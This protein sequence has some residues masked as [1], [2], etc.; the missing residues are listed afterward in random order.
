M[1]FS[2]RRLSTRHEGLWRHTIPEVL[3]SR[4]S[5]LHVLVILIYTRN[6][7]KYGGARLAR[8]GITF[9]DLLKASMACLQRRIERDYKEH[10]PFSKECSKNSL[11]LQ[12]T[13]FP[14]TRDFPMQTNI[15]I[16]SRI[17]SSFTFFKP[18]PTQLR[19]L[20]LEYVFLAAFNRFVTILST[21]WR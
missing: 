11:L 6:C 20:A 3:Y 12:T 8:V 13:N 14:I 16:Y 9:E 5:G 7:E 18:R 21:F 4:T 15:N 2:R 10:R 1:S 19:S 17:Q